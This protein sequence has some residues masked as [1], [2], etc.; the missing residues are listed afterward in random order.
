MTMKAGRLLVACLV[1]VATSTAVQAQQ[2]NPADRNPPEH[3]Q[4]IL[5]HVLFVRHSNNHYK[6]VLVSDIAYIQAAG[7][8]SDIYLT[9]REK[10]TYSISM[11]HVHEKLK[12]PLFVRVSRSHVINLDKVT[13]VKGNLL[14]ID[15]IGIQ[16]GETFKDAVMK[17]LPFLR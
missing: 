4:F 8:Y 2:A 12:Q 1:L 7:A 17:K 13:E 5:D 9:N 10:Y 11:N 14:M 3:D 15:E 6:K 16:M